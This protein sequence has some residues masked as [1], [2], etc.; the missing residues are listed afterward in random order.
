M[1]GCEIE[2]HLNPGSVAMDRDTNQIDV[3]EY[4]ERMVNYAAKAF[5]QIEFLPDAEITMADQIQGTN[6]VCP[7]RPK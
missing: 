5:Q 7:S 4:A 3:A 1:I 6:E 2:Q